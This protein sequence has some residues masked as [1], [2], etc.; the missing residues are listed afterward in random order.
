MP[1]LAAMT[2]N[3]VAKLGMAIVAGSRGF[4]LR[5]AP[6]LAGPMA[7]AWAVAAWAPFQ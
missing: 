7:A 3:T 6:G 1:I 5:I 2:S 4:A